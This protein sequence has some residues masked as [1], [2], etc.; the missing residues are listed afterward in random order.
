MD[1]IVNINRTLIN[2]F[3][4]TMK[5]LMWIWDRFRESGGKNNVECYYF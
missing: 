4:N 2:N 5:F 1:A 3:S